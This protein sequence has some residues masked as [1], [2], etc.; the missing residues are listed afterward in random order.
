MDC[1]SVLS[2]VVSLEAVDDIST[3]SENELSNPR[4]CCNES[5]KPSD[6]D[7][8]PNLPLVMELESESSTES[9]RVFGL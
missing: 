7:S 8:S 1:D 2:L 3:E 6:S 5:V 9:D 4:T